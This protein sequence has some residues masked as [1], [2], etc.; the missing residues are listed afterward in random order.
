MVQSI[1]FINKILD[2]SF[3]SGITC[4]HA[5][6]LSQK[7][8]FLSV[9]ITFRLQPEMSLES[10][11]SNVF[12]FCTNNFHNDWQLIWCNIQNFHIHWDA[13]EG[14][15]L[16]YFSHLGF[17][18]RHQYGMSTTFRFGPYWN[19]GS[20]DWTCHLVLNS[21][22]TLWLLE[23]PQQ[24]EIFRECVAYYSKKFWQKF[25]IMHSVSR[26]GFLLFFKV[27]LQHQSTCKNLFRWPSMKWQ[28][29][30]SRAEHVCLRTC[31]TMQII[32]TC[33]W[34]TV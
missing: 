26:C 14:R 8:S 1:S 11:L 22:T 7:A 6:I 3:H 23:P 24:L 30:Q 19:A 17:F 32:I 29:Q 21:K 20:Q 4:M 27:T 15:A 13:L 28:I 10:Y 31:A 25:R 16:D 12:I 2:W 33:W 5:C 9:L 34:Q 18:N